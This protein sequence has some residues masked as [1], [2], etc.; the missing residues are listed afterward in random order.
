MFNS[1]LFRFIKKFFQSVLFLYLLLFFTGYQLIDKDIQKKAIIV[2]TLN[3]FQSASSTSILWRLTRNEPVDDF[4]FI[5][6]KTY[7][8]MIYQF[9]PDKPEA[10]GLNGFFAYFDNNLDSSIAFYKQA[11]DINSHFFW[12]YYNLGIIFFKQ[13][14]YDQSYPLFMQALKQPIQDIIKT[15]ESSPQ[16]YGNIVSSMPFTRQKFA[17]HIAD[18]YE[19]AALFLLESLLRSERYDETLS[20][21]YNLNHN[22]MLEKDAMRYYAGLAFFHKKDYPQAS[23]QLKE[24]IENNKGDQQAG[25]Y[26]G[27]SLEAI[28]MEAQARQFLAIYSHLPPENSLSM[29]LDRLLPQPY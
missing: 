28:G 8:Q 22:G 2:R 14:N 16:I 23:L 26:L 24:F 9:F 19:H 6:T 21:A 13:G 11:I 25:Y 15:I 10:L 7:Y 5:K 3:N 29:S 17:K 4:L 12:Y 1:Q 18:G 27:R 20:A